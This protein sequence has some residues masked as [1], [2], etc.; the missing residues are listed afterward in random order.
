MIPRFGTFC[1]L[2]NELNKSKAKTSCLN[3]PKFQ[4]KDF[5]A[6]LCLNISKKIEEKFFK[7]NTWKKKKENWIIFGEFFSFFC[8]VTNK[9]IKG[10]FFSFFFFW[11]IFF[12]LVTENVQYKDRQKTKRNTK[13]I[14]I[15][16]NIKTENFP[17]ILR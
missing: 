2:P 13:W 6:L 11:E 4:S 16:E 14:L 8:L 5:S 17:S 10:I 9:L 7:E 15:A 3:S 1:L 12:C